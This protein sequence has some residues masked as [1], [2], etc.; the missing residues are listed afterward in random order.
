MSDGPARPIQ[1]GSPILTEEV[2]AGETV[3]VPLIEETARIE[4][5]VVETGRVRVSTHTDTVEQVLRE[6]L[7]GDAVEVTRVPVNRTLG[8]GE[9]APQ[10]RN[11]GGVIV[12]PVLEEVLVVEKRLVLKEEVH[13]R[14]TASGEEVE[15][16]V[17]LRRQRAEIERVG[18]EGEITPATSE[19]TGS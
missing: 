9:V 19:E 1:T 12:I 14:H 4:K 2:Q 15:F 10:V 18:P 17:T 5:R 13:V 6:T 7:R 11:E 3:L 8:E 16:P